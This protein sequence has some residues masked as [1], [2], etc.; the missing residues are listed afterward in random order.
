MTA[1]LLDNAEMIKLIA[2]IIG[3]AGGL[4]GFWK[5][6]RAQKEAHA[7]SLEL[8]K[9]ELEAR[10][11]AAKAKQIANYRQWQKTAVLSILAAEEAVEMSLTDIRLRFQPEI[12]SYQDYD[13][14]KAELSLGAL[15]RVLLEL[16]SVGA[17]VR[18]APDRFALKV[19]KE[20]P[21][22]KYAIQMNEEAIR[23]QAANTAMA[24]L[25]A[26][27]PAFYTRSSLVRALIDEESVELH[28]ASAVVSMAIA[29]NLLIVQ[30]ESGYTVSLSTDIGDFRFNSVGG[31]PPAPVP[32]SKEG[33]A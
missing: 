20:N 16:I 21:I 22:E 6:Y 25:A 2:T 26:K 3:I 14:P 33:A 24:R 31:P 15:Q 23:N 5:Y 1:W 29:Q 18:T 17:I 10:Q 7:K 12:Q 8:Q 4:F 9:A 19:E 28:R 30:P 13:V 32:M 11:E 27:R